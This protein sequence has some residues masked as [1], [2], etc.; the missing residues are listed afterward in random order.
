MLQNKSVNYIISEPTGPGCI[1]EWTS[2]NTVLVDEEGNIYHAVV[3]HAE[4][5]RILTIDCQH[6]VTYHKECLELQVSLVVKC[7]YKCPNA[8][9]ANDTT[10]VK[11]PG[12]GRTHVVPFVVG[13]IAVLL[14]FVLITIIICNKYRHVSPSKMIV[15]TPER[16]FPA[17]RNTYSHRCRNEGGD[18]PT[19]QCINELALQKGDML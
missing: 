3:L 11:H 6:N 13:G 19:C 5:Q 2:A 15:P 9:V 14:G 12:T 10:L 7:N 16:T 1:P 17:R 4:P 8:P 18:R